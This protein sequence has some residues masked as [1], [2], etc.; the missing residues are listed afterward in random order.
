MNRLV[1]L[2]AV[3][4]THEL[5]PEIT[6]FILQYCRAWNDFNR[7]LTQL[8]IQLIHPRGWTKCYLRRVRARALSSV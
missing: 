7:V 4:S 5:P 6:Y 2:Y 3:C 1:A 8:T